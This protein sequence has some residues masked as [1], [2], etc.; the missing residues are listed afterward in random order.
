[1]S[2]SYREIERRIGELYHEFNDGEV[3]LRKTKDGALYYGKVRE[4]YRLFQLSLNPLAAFLFS[5]VK[6]GY[7]CSQLKALLVKAGQSAEAADTHLERLVAIA[8]FDRDDVAISDDVIADKPLDS[9]L[10]VS[11]DITN[12]CN[13][14]CGYCINNSGPVLDDGMPLDACLSVA[15]QIAEAGIYVVWIGGGEPLLKK[16]IDQILRRLKAHN[17]KIILA[18][19]ATLLRKPHLLELVGE[20]CDEVNVS[21][22]G[23]TRESHARLRGASAHLEHTVG[24]VRLLKERFGKQVYV[25]A[26]TVVHKE[27]LDE[28]GD[29]IDF[30]YSIGC[31]KWTHDELYGLGGGST[32]TPLI[33]TH[34]GYDRMYEI[35]TAKADEYRGRMHVEEYV[36]MHQKPEAGTVKSFYGCIAGNQEV[37]IQHDGSVYPCQKLQYPKYYCGNVSETPLIEIWRNHPILKWLRQRDISQTE[38][39]GCKVFSRGQCNG[40]C[41]AEKEIVFQRHDTRDPLCPENRGLYEDMLLNGVEY[42]YL[43]QPSREVVPSDDHSRVWRPTSLVQITRKSH[44]YAH[45][46]GG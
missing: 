38:C 21:V 2:Y 9:P 18:T 42:P 6:E 25:T 43:S 15:D 29:I 39:S 37:A 45:A 40:G 28:L 34:D 14:T 24:G 12:T 36:R 33:L 20:T 7:G 16:G 27:N 3:A 32:L 17:V 22:D 1:M 8:N 30:V 26:L 35:V 11:W 10:T 23:A 31:D 46:R 13:L 5:R 4:K 41:L 19:N 44:G